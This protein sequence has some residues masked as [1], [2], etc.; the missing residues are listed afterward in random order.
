IP[1]GVAVLATDF[2][3]ARTAREALKVEWD[4]ENAFNL[5][6]AD[7]F[8]QYS[9][10]ARSPGTVAYRVGD[11]LKAGATGKVEGTFTFPYL[12]HA[13][14]EPLNCVVK[15]DKDGCEVWNG[16]QFQ[17]GDQFALAKALGVKP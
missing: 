9:D 1:T 5:S 16:E 6:S 10:L 14:M 8:K 13:A 4:D 7:I 2:W 15:L 11:T 3:S 12:A 17:T